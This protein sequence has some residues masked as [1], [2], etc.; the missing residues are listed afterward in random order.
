MAAHS[1]ESIRIVAAIG[2]GGCGKTTLLEQML[3]KAGATSRAGRVDDGS[4]ILD[5]DEEERERKITIDSSLAY[6]SHKDRELYLVDTPG[7]ADFIGS[8]YSSLSA[9]D[10]ALLCVAG[11]NGVEVNTRRVWRAARDAGKAC[12]VAVTKMDGEHIDA[13]GLLGRLKETLGQECVPLNLPVGTGGSFS[14]VVSTLF[15]PDSIPDGVIGDPEEIGLSLRESVV[16]GDEELMERYLADEEIKPE[17]MADALRKA[18]AGGSIVPVL[19][20]S[21]D[22][23]AGVEELLDAVASY[24]PSPLDM[25]ARK[26]AD[27]SGEN[28]VEV[29][30]DANAPLAAQ[31]FKCVND[32]FVGRMS[33]FRI[34]AGSLTSDGSFKNLRTGR[35]EKAAH[36]FRVQGKEQQSIERAV[37][38]DLVALTKIEDMKL[39][40]SLCA[41]ERPIQ[42]PEIA[43]PTPMASLAVEP[44]SRG[45]EQKI[46]L[47][48]NK[49]A[50]EDQTFHVRRDQR[51]HEMVITGMSPLHVEVMIKRLK[52]RFGVEVTSKQP[53]IAYLE[54]I[55]G[56]SDV[57]YRHK[58]QTGEVSSARSGFAWRRSNAAAGSS[59]STRSWAGP[60][61]VSTSRRW[62]R[63][64]ARRWHAACWPAA[65]WWTCR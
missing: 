3:F 21:G 28:E 64:S 1:T 18:V 44:K 15:P 4:S 7:Y 23:G 16:E 48:L 65:K 38:G 55:T 52:R 56:K 22:R 41:P 46:S 39:G 2:H 12:M 63:A 37:P 49:L 53:K 11:P 30:P 10:T 27:V 13:D 40:D 42:F 5:F 14:G 20:C 26:G 61:R 50:E 32:P 62:K 58:K 43:F 60:S 45:D 8:V 24:C 36:L 29:A 17:E 35:T 19:F 59:S 57:Q 54:T 31:V 51:T 34:L 9:A 25:P 6:C 47:S 33:F